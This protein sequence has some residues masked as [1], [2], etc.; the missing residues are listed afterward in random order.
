R[1]N[2]CFFLPNF[3]CELNPIEMVW[4]QAKRR[5]CKLSDGTFPRAKQLVPECLDYVK[6]SNIC[7]YFRLCYRYLEAYR[8][9][10]NFQQVAYAVKKYKSHRRIPAN[11]MMDINIISQGVTS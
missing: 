4:G 8:R 5:F 3:H 7:R 11:I 6:T 2:K 1:N 10:L 9:G